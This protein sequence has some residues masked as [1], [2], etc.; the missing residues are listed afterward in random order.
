MSNNSSTAEKVVVGTLAVVGVSILAF[1]LGLAVLLYG[2]FVGG[3]VGMKLWAWFIVP[4]FGLNPITVVQAWGIALLVELWS[5]QIH[6]NTNKD[7]REP[8]AKVATFIT[9]LLNPWIILFIG[10]AGKTLFM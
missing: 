3:F 7:E 8:S 5:H 4:V 6:V 1:M 2:V 10:W 9:V